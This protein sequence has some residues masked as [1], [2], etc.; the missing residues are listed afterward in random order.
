MVGVYSDPRRYNIHS[1]PSGSLVNWVAIV[2]ECVQVDGELSISHES[3][4]LS[5][6]DVDDLPE[7]TLLSH[8]I[9]ISDAVYGAAGPFIR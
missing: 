9:R 1:Y 2:F 3:T 4:D 8:G 7:N 5:Y 6:F